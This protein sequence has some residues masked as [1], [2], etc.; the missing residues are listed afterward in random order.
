MK[1]LYTGV[2][3]T[4]GGREGN[5]RSDDGIL[6]LD[7]SM[8]KAMG[9]K[10][11][12][13]TNPEQLFAAGY[14]ACYGSALQVVAKKHKVDLGDFSVTASVELGTTEEGDLQLSVVLDSYIPGVD[15]ETGEKLVNE[16][17]EICPYSRA[18]RDNIDV[19]L[20][21]MLDEDE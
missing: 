2:A 20:N 21:L 7:L 9:G 4:T 3:T 12:E 14:S 13:K 6:D 17:H 16:A 1:T 5:V 18:T 10:G 15:V 19:T 11:A 8:P